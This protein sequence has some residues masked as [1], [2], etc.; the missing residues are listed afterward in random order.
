MLKYIPDHLK[1]KN[2]WK[3]A[4]KKLPFIKKYVPDRL[5]MCDRVALKMA[6]C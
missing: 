6:E 2:M 3:H 1:T 5:R 4:V